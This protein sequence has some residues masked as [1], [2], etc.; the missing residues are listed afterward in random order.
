MTKRSVIIKQLADMLSGNRFEHTMRVE[1]IAKKLAR[2]HRISTTKASTAAL[3]HD[4]ARKHSPKTLLKLAKKYKLKV[5]PLEKRQPKL[6]HAK[7]SAI[8]ARLDFGITD[9]GILSAISKHTLGSPAMTKLEKI[10]Y[11]ADHVE[12]G[13]Q[14]KD[15]DKIRRLAF[16][17]LDQAVI[18]VATNMLEYLL[19]KGQTISPGTLV[20]LNYYL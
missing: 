5:S 11:I 7:L 6:L 3:L 4:Y 16:K 9:P 17:N 12:V 15:T 1:Q 19:S 20:T 14:H 2:H 18:A 8:L 10:I 13:R